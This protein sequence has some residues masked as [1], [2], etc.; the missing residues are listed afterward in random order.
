MFK[1]KV[2]DK[3][4]TSRFDSIKSNKANRWVRMSTGAMEDIVGEEEI[5]M[6]T[7][8]YHGILR[9]Q[10]SNGWMWPESSL[11]LVEDKL[12]KQFNLGD[13][14]NVSH[15][16]SRC[17]EDNELYYVGMKR[18]GEY[19]VENEDGIIT[20]WEYCRPFKEKITYNVWKYQDTK[21]DFHVL[22]EGKL[23]I[24]CTNWKIIHTFTI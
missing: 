3:V 13:K 12:M 11:T 16:G 5:I 21:E 10:L 22:R 4:K 20:L 23:P 18:N 6:G 24:A 7:E 2:G 19:I 1:F 8:D 17:T 14:V 9:Y 15:S